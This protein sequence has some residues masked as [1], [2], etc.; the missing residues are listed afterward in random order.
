MAEHAFSLIYYSDSL[1]S[2]PEE[3]EQA[4]VV[5]S[6]LLGLNHNRYN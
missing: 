4:G 3:S 2:P 5:L 6:S 1:P